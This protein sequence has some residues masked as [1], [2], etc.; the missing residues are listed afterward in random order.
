[1]KGVTTA[2]HGDHNTDN[3]RAPKYTLKTIN[4]TCKRK[5]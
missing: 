2:P 4:K 1:M 5:H 3:K